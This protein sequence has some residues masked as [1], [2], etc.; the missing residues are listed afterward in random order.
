MHY[1]NGRKLFRA[2]FGLHNLQIYKGERGKA[3]QEGVRW[4]V[5]DLAAEV[6]RFAAVCFFLK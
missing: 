1:N 6:S 3:S 2:F 4:W 5:S